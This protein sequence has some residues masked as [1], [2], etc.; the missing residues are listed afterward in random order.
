MDVSVLHVATG[1]GGSSTF[2]TRMTPGMAHL[3]IYLVSV[4]E[5]SVLHV[6]SG[7]SGSST[8]TTT[9]NTGIGSPT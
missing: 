4:Y 7:N 5:F 1:S 2:T 6:V 3:L 8:S 9:V